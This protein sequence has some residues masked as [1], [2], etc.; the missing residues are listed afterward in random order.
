MNAV[1][2]IKNSNM[3]FILDSGAT[4]HVVNDKDLFVTQEPA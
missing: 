3:E 2:E 4:C 1:E